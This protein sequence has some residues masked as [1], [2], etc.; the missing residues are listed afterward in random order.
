MNNSVKYLIVA[1]I[2]FVVGLIFLKSAYEGTTNYP[3]EQEIVLIV[4][5]TIATIAITASL[6]SKQSEIELQKEQRVKVF[7]IK[8]NLYFELIS[9]IEKLIRTEKIEENDLITL[10]FLTHKI[11]ILA[12]PEV[13]REYT[14]FIKIIKETSIDHKISPME[15]E[16][17]SASLAKLCGKIRY[18]LLPKDEQNHEEIQSII[19][20]NIKQI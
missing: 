18:D 20:Q 17:L 2:T 19:D 9:F 7:D 16:T 1:I 8:S 10:E 12:S 3:F 13:L 4:L 11:S 15:S 14:H 5:G 6:L